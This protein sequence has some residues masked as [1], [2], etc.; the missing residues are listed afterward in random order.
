M[1]LFPLHWIIRKLVK[2]TGIVKFFKFSIGPPI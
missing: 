2:L 1:E